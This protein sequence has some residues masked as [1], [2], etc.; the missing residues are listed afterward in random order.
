MREPKTKLPSLSLFFPCYNEENNVEPS[1]LSA[2]K[3]LKDVA[4]CFE[5]IIINDGSSDNTKTVAENLAGIYKEVRVISHAKNRGYGGAVKTGF[6]NAKYEWTF[7]TDGDLQFDLGQLKTF[8]KY[9]DD[10]NI[11]I[12]YRKNRA[13]G[14]RRALIARSFKKLVDMLFKL[15]VEDI[16]CAFK[17]IN[18]GAVRKIDLTCEGAFV[19]VE[20]LYKLKKQGFSF[21]ELP[22]DHYNRKSG[23]A[24][25][26]NL[27]VGIRQIADTLKFYFHLKTTT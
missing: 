11:I 23:E 7:F 25:G 15:G 16:D 24:T 9:T 18:T 20:L 1:V 17:L 8:I 27:K 14:L 19:S 21:K 22:V 26:N 12:G 10:Y 2:L 4:D 5:I 6:S 13:E 3:V